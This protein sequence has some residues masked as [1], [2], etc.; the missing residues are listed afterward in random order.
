VQALEILNKIM[1]DL[2]PD[3][4]IEQVEA[5]IKE[6]SNDKKIYLY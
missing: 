6:G 4:I 5:K 1:P 2:I 3:N